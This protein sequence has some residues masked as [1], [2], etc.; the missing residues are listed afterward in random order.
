MRARAL[1]GPIASARRR[2]A[3]EVLRRRL[4]YITATNALPLL[5]RPGR[6]QPLAVAMVLN[7]KIKKRQRRQDLADLLE[8]S[9]E[10]A[11]EED[12]WDARLLNMGLVRMSSRE[13]RY[14]SEATAALRVVK[15]R[16][17]DVDQQALELTV[18]FKEII[19]KERVKKE[20]AIGEYK[21]DKRKRARARAA[22]KKRVMAEFPQH[23]T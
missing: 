3:I 9:I 16:V 6:R 19:A 12:S 1:T 14:E 20:R 10:T 23:F 11:K 5:R 7:K 4:P 8:D 15:N 17:R 13:E 22:R 18:R 21:R 2:K